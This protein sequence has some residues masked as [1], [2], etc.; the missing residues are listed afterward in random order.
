MRLIFLQY[1]R[2]WNYLCNTEACKLFLGLI[3]HLCVGDIYF[4]RIGSEYFFAFEYYINKGYM[5]MSR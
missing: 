2:T 4:W 1:L 3:F 5:L